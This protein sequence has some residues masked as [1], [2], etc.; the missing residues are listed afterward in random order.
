MILIERRLHPF[1]TKRMIHWIE[2][3]LYRCSSDWKE[4]R[5][6]PKMFSS[7]FSRLVWKRGKQRTIFEWISSTKFFGMRQKAL[8]RSPWI[9]DEP[10]NTIA[11]YKKNVYK[12]C[13]IFYLI[14][15]ICVALTNYA[16]GL[17]KIRRYY[18][19]FNR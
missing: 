1:I 11:V 14:F 17:R 12:N 10:T 7:F 18:M 4:I 2:N 15:R 9:F 19:P 8:A 13:L 16:R 6:A 5:L 3:C